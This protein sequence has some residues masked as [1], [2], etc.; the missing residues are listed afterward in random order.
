MLILFLCSEK[1]LSDPRSEPRRLSSFEK[2]LKI[3]RGMLRFAA[4]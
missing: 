1:E 2:E 4:A 3:W